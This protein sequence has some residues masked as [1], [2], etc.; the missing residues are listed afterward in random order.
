MEDVVAVA[1]GS[2]FSSIQVTTR[3]WEDGVNLPPC[4]ASAI[5]PADTGVEANARLTLVLSE[6]MLAA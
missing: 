1:T 5:F 6:L 3:M 4:L 2:I